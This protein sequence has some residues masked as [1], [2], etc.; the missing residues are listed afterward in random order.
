MI[1]AAF[2]YT[3]ATSLAEVLEAIGGGE[4]QTKL[5]C[6]GQTLV[7][8]LRFRLAQPHRLLDIAQLPELRGI[9]VTDDG[10]RIGAATTYRELLA[11]EPLCE[12][13]PL[14]AEV[15]E[16]I[17]DIQVRNLGTIGGALAHADPSADMPAAMLA[18]D[19]R[20][21]L[22]SARAQR[23]V[24]AREFFRGPL[25]TAMEPD[26]LL[27]AIEL[28]PLSDFTGAA[29]V[30]FEQAASGYALVGAAAVVTRQPG[31]RRHG[32]IARLH[33]TR[34]RAISRG[35][36]VAHRH[37]GQRA[38]DRAR[39]SGGGA[40]C[41]GER[42]HPRRCGVSPPAR[43]GRSAAR[44]ERR[45]RTRGRG[46]V[47]LE[48][49]GVQ[50]IDAPT[51]VV[52]SN[53]TDPAFVAAAAAGVESV[54]PI[55]AEHFRVVALLGVGSIS[56]RFTLHVQLH[57]VDPLVGL[58]MSVQGAAPGSAMRVEAGATLAPLEGGATRLAWTVRST[59]MARSPGSARA[60]SR[61]RCDGR[62]R[63]SGRSS[64]RTA[65]RRRGL[66][67]EDVSG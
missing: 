63:G 8:L 24:A 5:I 62:S 53:L 26:E 16:N 22:Q 4:Q 51:A 48:T 30:T 47:R 3:R 56:L 12:A 21:H 17:G 20:F 60:C 50:E 19:A 43:K 11:C 52:W 28:E 7:P 13:V 18:L 49:S 59:C 66:T 1:P 65:C 23:V 37:C 35:C 39:G 27:V 36:V 58:R 57:D 45:H 44:V 67:D 6:G 34:R 10:I 64:P 55:D 2:E 40:W 15:T 41:A 31:E 32:G 38:V 46:N 29:Y 54:A 61:G 33:R 25:E 9:S 42:R 14:I